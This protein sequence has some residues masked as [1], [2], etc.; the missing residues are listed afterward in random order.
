MTL[1]EY[2]AI[3]FVLVMQSFEKVDGTWSRRAEYPELPGCF[4]EAESP[5]DAVEEVE[6]KR[7][8]YIRDLLERGASVPVPRQPLPHKM[9]KRSFARM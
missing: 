8:R 3:P 5:L 1:D 9:L 4:A 6:A 7:I 2:L